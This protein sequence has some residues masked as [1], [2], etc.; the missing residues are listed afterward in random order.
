M[1]LWYRRD[2]VEVPH[3]V[4]SARRMLLAEGHDEE[5]L[6]REVGLDL[7]LELVFHCE[8]LDSCAVLALGELEVSPGCHCRSRRA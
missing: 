5:V 3:L 2:S 7:F 8:V 4:L 1:I 6:R